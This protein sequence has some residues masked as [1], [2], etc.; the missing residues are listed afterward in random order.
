MNGRGSPP[1]VSGVETVL[2]DRD[3]TTAD[4][5]AWWPRQARDLA[6]RVAV[7]LAA[8]AAALCPAL[9]SLGGAV[10]GTLLAV[11]TCTHAGRQER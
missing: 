11:A 3:V 1:R 8:V 2:Q 5:L 7:R 9:S 6:I 10:V 4:A